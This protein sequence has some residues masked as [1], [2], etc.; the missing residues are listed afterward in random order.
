[1]AQTICRVPAT[2]IRLLEY[3]EFATSV[4]EIVE[5]QD[6]EALKIKGVTDLLKAELPEIEKITVKERYHPI[7]KELLTLKANRDKTLGAILSLIQGYKKQQVP[8]L[9]DAV[10][11]ALPFLDRFLTKINRNSNFIKNKKIDLLFFELAGNQEVKAA[12][13]TLGFT[14]LLDDL[15]T[16][17][18]AILAKQK[19]RRE[20]KSVTPRVKGRKIVVNA[21]VAMNNLFRTIEINQLVEK[22][23]DYLPLIN[24]LNEMLIEYKTLLTQRSTLMQKAN[25]IK[26]ETVA[27]SSTT[28]ATA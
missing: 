4:I 23:V 3:P 5:K 27:S 25:S 13:Q 15:K 16:N 22:N 12:L 26:K 14:V 10:F 17:Y 2:A 1:M 18:Q 11:I 21:T 7:T 28:T 20:S 24:E 6:L 19:N 9:A 8:A